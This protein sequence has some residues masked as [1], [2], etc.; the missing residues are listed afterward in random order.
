M[1][2]LRKVRDFYN[3]QYLLLETQA[4]LRQEVQD[5][6]AK[7]Q[8]EFFLRQQ[9]K[10][11]QKE[12]GEDDA[13]ADDLDALR[14]KL[15]AANLPEATRKE[16]DREL[17]RLGRMNNASPEYQMVRTYLEWIA[18]LPWSV[19]TGGAIDVRAA[20]EVLD[21][22]HY[23]L[24]S[25]KERILEYLAVKQRRAARGG[26]GRSREP[27]LAFV[28]P[29]GVG[30]T[31]LGQSIAKALGRTFVRMSPGR[32]ARRGRATRLSPH[33][34]RLAAGPRDPGAAPRR[35]RRP[36]DPAR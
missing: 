15:T 12:L 18:E 30:K 14:E 32:R 28:G 11:I 25:V 22:D 33:L 4:K 17:G 35:H 29:P 5:S 1:A 9:M 2:R 10:A 24:E 7:Q 27:I 34:H 36:G 19:T 16:A 8:R 3:K 23:G 6:A 26:D 20:R 13:D 31:S 21:S